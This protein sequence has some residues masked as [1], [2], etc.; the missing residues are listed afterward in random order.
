MTQVIG[1]KN[2]NCKHIFYRIIIIVS[3]TRQ[4]VTWLCELSEQTPTAVSSPAHGLRWLR[5]AQNTHTESGTYLIIGDLEILLY[6]IVEL[7][8]LLW[9][10]GSLHQCHIDEVVCG[11]KQ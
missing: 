3:E 5:V 4:L 1:A 8:Q 7:V 11:T 10:I 9:Q 6:V 2:Q